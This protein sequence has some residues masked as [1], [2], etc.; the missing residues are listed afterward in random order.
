M[1]TELTLEESCKLIELGVNPKLASSTYVGRWEHY[2]TGSYPDPD[3]I[4]PIFKLTD[5]LAILPCEIYSEER[6][7]FYFLTIVKSNFGSSVQYRHT[8]YTKG[9]GPKLSYSELIDALYQLLTWCINNGHYNPK[10]AR[11]EKA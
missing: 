11:N 6:D 4:E 10:M 2:S 1:K 5:I 8:C 7:I 9:F 3:S